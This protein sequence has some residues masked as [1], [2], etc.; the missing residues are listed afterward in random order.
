MFNEIQY[1]D[2]PEPYDALAEKFGIDVALELAKMFS[3]ERVYFLKYEAI[4]RP[5]RNK[6]IKSEFNGY[7]FRFLA[8]KYNMTEMGIRQIV[9]DEISIKQS[10][11]NKHQISFFDDSS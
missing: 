3:G 1:E 9:A 10:E 7:N 5:L 11:P 4:E 6:K 8:K 2:L